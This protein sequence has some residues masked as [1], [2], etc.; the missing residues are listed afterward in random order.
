ML[1]PSAV[2]AVRT[3]T[4]TEGFPKVPPLRIF[5]AADPEALQLAVAAAPAENDQIVGAEGT[6]VFLD[7]EAATL[8]DDKILDTTAGSDG[9]GAFV[10]LPQA[11][12]ATAE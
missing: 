7:R 5:T 11:P 2:E 6:Q 1:T 3:I 8:L 4:S 10:V 12:D 9:D